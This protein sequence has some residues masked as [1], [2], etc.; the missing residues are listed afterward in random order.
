M[1]SRRSAVTCASA[2]TDGDPPQPLS[3][4]PLSWSLSEAASKDAR[5]HPEPARVRGAS[6][7]QVALARTAA[8]AASQLW[9][10]PKPSGVRAAL[11]PSFCGS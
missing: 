6:V 7:E 5:S 8:A 3:D 11:Q 9:R 2:V 10:C 4:A 1:G